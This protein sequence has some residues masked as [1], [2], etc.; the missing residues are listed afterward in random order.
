MDLGLILFN[1][2]TDDNFANS[3]SQ[4]A[5]GFNKGNLT[6]AYR[7]LGSNPYSEVI[8]ENN[9]LRYELSQGKETEPTKSMREL[10]EEY[11]ELKKTVYGKGFDTPVF[12]ATLLT[13][14]SIIRG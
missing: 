12:N 13:T 14:A 1:K 6:E 10:E 5:T 4:I 11:D 7:K 2:L 3:T 8:L 9:T